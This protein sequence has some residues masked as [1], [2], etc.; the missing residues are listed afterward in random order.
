MKTHQISRSLSVLATMFCMI[1]SVDCLAAPN[2]PTPKSPTG[3]TALPENIVGWWSGSY[4]QLHWDDVDYPTQGYNIYSKKP[5]DS[6][7]HRLN[8]A[9]FAQTTYLDRKSTR[10]NSSH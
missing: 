9:P 8:S 3:T 2:P 10:L 6:D 4:V 1:L 5:Q 7:W